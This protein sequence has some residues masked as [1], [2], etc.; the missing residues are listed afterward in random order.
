MMYTGSHDL[1]RSPCMPYAVI[2]PFS[3]SW[4][5][6]RFQGKQV[7]ELN[8]DVFEKFLPWQPSPAEKWLLEK[9]CF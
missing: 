5:P 6:P 4:V 8:A 9:W 7:T 2:G 1:C 3:V